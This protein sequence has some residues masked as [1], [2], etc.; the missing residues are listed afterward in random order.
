MAQ[1]ISANPRR[2]F[3]F[4]KSQLTQNVTKTSDDIE[5]CLPS[6]IP[7]WEV[8]HRRVCRCEGENRSHY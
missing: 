8:E 7:T 6:L 2:R 3:V 5:G 4:S 1:K